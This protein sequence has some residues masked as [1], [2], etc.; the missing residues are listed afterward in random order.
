MSLAR[1]SQAGVT[2]IESQRHGAGCELF[3]VEGESAAGAVA[4]VR[5]ARTQAVLACQ[6]KPLNAWRATP[7]PTRCTRNWPA[8]W[9][10]HRSWTAAPRR[11]RA[12]SA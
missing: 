8:R 10:G 1:R 9:A 4:A 12:S 3:L 5:D 6:G 7:A 2:L 11:R